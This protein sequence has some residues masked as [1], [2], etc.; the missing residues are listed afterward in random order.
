MKIVLTPSLLL[1]DEH[2][3][4]IGV[5]RMVHRNGAPFEEM[6]AYSPHQIVSGIYASV[7][8][9]P[10]RI[11][12]RRFGDAKSDRPREERAAINSFCQP[13]VVSDNLLSD[14]A[15]AVREGGAS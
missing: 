6:P 12:V 1:T 4:A 3:T 8:S 10:A 9:Q 15:L 14:P 2:P 11:L 5:L 7:V 13:V